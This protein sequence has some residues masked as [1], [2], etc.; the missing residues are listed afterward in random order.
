MKKL[1]A[2]L[3]CIVCLFSSVAVS[4]SAANGLTDQI[5]SILGLEPDETIAYGIIYDTNDLS[6]GVTSIMYTPRPTVTLTSKGTY[7]VTDDIPLAVDYEFVCWVDQETGKYYRA[8][9]KYYV[10]GQ[11]TLHAVWVEKTDNNGRLIRILDTAIDTFIRNIKSML[12]VFKVEF[13]AE[14]TADN[15]YEAK[16]YFTINQIKGEDG[17]EFVWWDYNAETRTLTAKIEL[18]KNVDYYESFSRTEPI[19]LGGTVIKLEKDKVWKEVIETKWVQ[20]EDENGELVWVEEP[21]KE[22]QMVQKIDENGELVWVEEPVTEIVYK[23]IDGKI[24]EVE[25]EK[26]KYIWVQES[27]FEN[28]L[29][30]YEQVSALY[31][32]KGLED[33]VKGEDG[34]K[35]QIIRVTIT[36]GA[37]SALAGAF[38][39]LVFTKGMLRYKDLG[40]YTYANN[41]CYVRGIVR[42]LK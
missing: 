8:G 41:E 4:A 21:V 42:Y 32:T 28:Q 33:V 3:L 23:E 37:P 38:V 11:K 30:D 1:T 17:R 29:V 19:C 39:T 9:D 2:V 10:N 22:T 5:G 26:Y 13:V 7:T 36:D 31:E 6:S 34:K 25:V 14:P 35:Y 24:V 18:P 40:E 27:T 16:D 12:G 20:K 15:F